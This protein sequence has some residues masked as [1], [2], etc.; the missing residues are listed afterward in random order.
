MGSFNAT[1]AVSGAVIRPSDKVRLV[2]LVSNS[3]HTHDTGERRYSAN[4]KHL[5]QG[6]MCYSYDDFEILGVPLEAT[7][8]DYNN[9]SYNE[10]GVEWKYTLKEIQRIYTP[11]VIPESGEY[12][13]CHDYVN[14]DK[15][16]LDSSTI[17]DMIHSGSLN[18]KVYGR[19]VF[20]THMAI[21]ESI[22]KLMLRGNIETYD[23]ELQDYVTHSMFESHEKQYMKE[24]VV[25][26][27]RGEQVAN[28][29]KEVKEKKGEVLSEEEYEEIVALFSRCGAE[30]CRGF[31]YSPSNLI[32]ARTPELD[33]AFISGMII[34]TWFD[35][36][37][38]CLQPTPSGSQEYDLRPHIQLLR[39]MADALEETRKE[40]GDDDWD[41]EEDEEDE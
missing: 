21:H 18:G 17:Q 30:H 10:E 12:N 27:E 4:H 13:S 33:K 5:F 28:I 9:W 36:N 40:R 35:M 6:Y 22:Y 15:E 34:I 2:F 19:K 24:H 38:K 8:E 32:K 23:R 31:C 3:A 26:R 11:N 14:I 7:Y 1:C 41:D 20:I 25:S 37:H 39:D 29:T 16:A